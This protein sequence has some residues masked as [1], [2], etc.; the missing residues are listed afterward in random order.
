MWAQ[1]GNEAATAYMLT[2]VE[3]FWMSG[4]VCVNLLRLDTSCAP[5]SKIKNMKDVLSNICAFLMERQLLPAMADLANRHA[6]CTPTFCPA[7]EICG[8]D[9][10]WA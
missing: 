7:C 8:V 10:Q 6:H 5:L 2:I 3:R 9:S 1:F 4:L